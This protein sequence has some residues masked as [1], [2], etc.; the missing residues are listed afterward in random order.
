MITQ[1][2]KALAG[3][4]HVV[5]YYT[6]DECASEVQPRTFH[7]YSLI[8]QNDPASITFAVENLPGE[9]QFWRDTVDVL[10]VDPTLS[11]APRT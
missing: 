8:K 9:Y 11:A 7:Q 4:S 10:G 2:A 3:D 6:C 5:G 1:Y